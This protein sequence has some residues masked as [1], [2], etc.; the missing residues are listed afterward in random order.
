[1]GADAVEVGTLRTRLV[2]ASQTVDRFSGR[3]AEVSYE[4]QMLCSA[5]KALRSLHFNAKYEK[6]RREDSGRFSGKALFS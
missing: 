2:D 5:L 1:M 4:R 3:I 6:L